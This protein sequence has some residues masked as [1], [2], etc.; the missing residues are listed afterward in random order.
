LFDP[1]KIADGQNELLT[2]DFKIDDDQLRKYG[3]IFTDIRK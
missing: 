1:V 3:S 2:S